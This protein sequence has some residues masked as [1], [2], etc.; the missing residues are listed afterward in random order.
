MSQ[1]PTRNAPPT[2]AEPRDDAPPIPEEAPR[3]PGPAGPGTIRE[4][5]RRDAERLRRAAALLSHG[6]IAGVVAL[7]VGASATLTA[8]VFSRPFPYAFMY[9]LMGFLLLNLLGIRFVAVA[10]GRRTAAIRAMITSLTLHAFFLYVLF[11][12]IPARTVVQRRL[13]ERPDQWILLL[14][15]GLYLAAMA[16]MIIQGFLVRR[17]RRIAAQG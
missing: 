4:Q 9:P 15:I 1:D 17:S 7:H 3:S 14:P 13:I 5:V 16:G 8:I 12:Q 2:T 6:A 10:A 11:D